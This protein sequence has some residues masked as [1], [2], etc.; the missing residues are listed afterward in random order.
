MDISKVT[1][2]H[3]T[4]DDKPG[5]LA[6][7]LD[8][9]ARAGANLGFV[10]ARRS[11]DRPGHGVVF[12]TPL[13]G[14]AQEGAAKASGFEVSESLHGL[15]IEGD[16]A[17]GLGAKLTAALAGAGINLRGLSAA[18]FGSKFIMHLAFDSDSDAAKAVSTLGAM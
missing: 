6:A 9:L 1:V 2:W 15:R 10:I 13:E 3:A 17:P 4:I 8:A 5:G 18:A 14:G 7:K 12:V 16:D 11:P